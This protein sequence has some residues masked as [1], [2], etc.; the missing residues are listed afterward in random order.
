MRD[1]PG[2]PS[3]PLVTTR[4]PAVATAAP[5]E[6]QGGAPPIASFP[7]PGDSDSDEDPEEGDGEEG[8]A[9]RQAGSISRSMRLEIARTHVN[10]GHPSRD[11]F[12]KMLLVAQARP[13]VI[14]YVKHEFR[15]EQ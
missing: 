7:A 6:C 5:F 4:A 13:E 11:A 1:L 2:P 15:C 12:L 9:G 3:E 14:E 8:G 10:L